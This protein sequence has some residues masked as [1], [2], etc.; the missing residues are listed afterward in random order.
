MVLAGAF[1]T[2]GTLHFV[3]PRPF[4]Q[5]MPPQI[6][7][8]WHRLLVYVSGFFE[9][10]GGIGVLPT[11]TRTAAG[12]GLL[13]LLVAVFPANVQMLI[14]YSRAKA[15]AAVLAGLWIRLPLQPALMWWV[16]SVTL[17]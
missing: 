4:E 11:A 15:P 12:V 17:R 7:K 9:L 10:A 1:I 3:A 8:A 5:I 16:W 6:P 14:N 2:M 13:L